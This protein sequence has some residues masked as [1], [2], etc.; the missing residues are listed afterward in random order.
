MYIIMTMMTDINLQVFFQLVDEC[1]SSSCVVREFD[2]KQLPSHV[3]NLQ[4]E[5]YRPLVMQVNDQFTSV[6]YIL[7]LWKENE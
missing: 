5:A 4:L 2:W 6:I 1:N 7:F 3:K